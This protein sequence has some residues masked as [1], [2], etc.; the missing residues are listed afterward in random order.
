MRA[1]ILSGQR[2]RCAPGSA[3]PGRFA[4]RVPHTPGTEAGRRPASVEGFGRTPDGKT[5]RRR[6][7]RYGHRPAFAPARGRLVEAPHRRR[8]STE[9]QPPGVC[10]G[11]TRSATRRTASAENGLDLVKRDVARRP[12]EGRNPTEQRSGGPCKAPPPLTQTTGKPPVERRRQPPF[13]EGAC[14]APVRDEASA[15]DRLPRTR[16]AVKR[17]RRKATRR[18]WRVR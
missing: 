7:T 14:E 5:A 6:A 1:P 10:R 16:R 18:A 3:A 11:G 4:C 15:E 8:R 13:P 17:D 9:G 12:V 2:A